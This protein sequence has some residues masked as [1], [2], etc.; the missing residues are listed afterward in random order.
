[1][2]FFAMT[3][4]ISR[5]LKI[6]PALQTNWKVKTE[7]WKV[8]FAI[9]ARAEQ[10][11]LICRAVAKSRHYVVLPQRWKLKCVVCASHIYIVI[12][13][14]C[15][16][17]PYWYAI[18]KYAILW[19]TPRLSERRG[20]ACRLY[21]AWAVK[22]PRRGINLPLFY[23]FADTHNSQHYNPHRSYTA[24]DPHVGA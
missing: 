11:Y 15:I 23:A 6:I 9:K 12:A 4:F 18:S 22:S 21:R 5:V 7:K 1:M 20:C 2:Q 10:V 13:K 17:Q 16:R 24:V 3:A 8:N 14:N 19:T